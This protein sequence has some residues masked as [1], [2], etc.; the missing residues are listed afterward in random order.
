VDRRFQN[1][2]IV[3]LLILA[4]TAC[5][6]EA[7]SPTV[8]PP[9]DLPKR[10][11]TVFI[12]PTP[13]ADEQLATRSAQVLTPLPGTATPLPSPT[14][15]VGVF[16]GEAALPDEGPIYS[17]GLE[18]GPGAT[19]TPISFVVQNCPVSVDTT[20]FGTA[21]QQDSEVVSRL[22]CPIEALQPFI[23][24]L[25]IFERGAI[26]GRGNG[27]LWAVAPQQ[28]RYWYVT[29]APSTAPGEISPPESLLPPD[30]SFGGL[31]RGLAGVSDALGWGRTQIQQASFSTQRFEGGALF[32]DR[33]SGQL[34]VLWLDS[35]MAGPY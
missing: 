23:G 34:Y 11:A 26:Y 22:G 21:W 14:A 32:L 6:A 33:A 30:P 5:G 31:W 29:T 1:T 20:I 7:I 28:S 9:A 25:Q 8:A 18:T 10:L 35:T 24:T 12:S 19:E 16:L 3:L 2:F 27:E 13:N 17:G 15:Y 4:L